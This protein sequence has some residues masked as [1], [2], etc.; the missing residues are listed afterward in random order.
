MRK[1]IWAVYARAIGDAVGRRVSEREAAAL[2][3][4]LAKLAG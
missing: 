3:N 4:L 2:A 1:R